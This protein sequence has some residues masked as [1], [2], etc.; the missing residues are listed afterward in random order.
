VTSRQMNMGPFGMNQEIGVAM[1][2]YMFIVFFAGEHIA[3]V[4]FVIVDSIFEWH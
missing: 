3:L 1:R 2:F 4:E